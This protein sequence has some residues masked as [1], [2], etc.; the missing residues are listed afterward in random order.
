[1]HQGKINTRIAHVLVGCCFAELWLRC[2]GEQF[3][4]HDFPQHT[5]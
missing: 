4:S 1:M 2:L 5:S 3:F